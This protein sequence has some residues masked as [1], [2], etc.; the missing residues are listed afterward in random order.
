MVRRMDGI[1]LIRDTHAWMRWLT[2]RTLHAATAIPDLDFRRE[3]PIGCGSI[4]GTLTHLIGAERVW[5]GALQ[6]DAAATMATTAEF[7]SIASMHAAWPSVRS[8]W[9]AYLNQLTDT[10]CNRIIARVRDGKEF[11]QQVS[12]VLLQLPT[13]ALYHNAQ[14]SFMFRQMGHSLPDSSWIL[15]RRE[16]LAHANP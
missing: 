11:R 7:P 12:D 15:W 8:R 3:F 10:E 6:G 16:Q 5:I 1:T 14:M 4:H 9:D 13:H 2:G